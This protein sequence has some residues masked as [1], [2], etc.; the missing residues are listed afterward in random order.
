MTKKS[1]ELATIDPNRFAVC[2]PS[3]QED[4]SSLLAGG[5]GNLLVINEV[6]NNP[7]NEQTGEF[8]ELQNL[9]GS[10]D[11]F[12][13]EE[14]RSLAVTEHMRRLLAEVTVVSWV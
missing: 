9:G 7:L 3:A 10:L 14:R 11:F 1:T 6:M 8:V 5:V 2:D 12:S 13:V 4:L